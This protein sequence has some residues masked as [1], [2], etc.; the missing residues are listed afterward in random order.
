MCSKEGID[1]CAN[2]NI[3]RDR[4]RKTQAFD[5]CIVGAETKLMRQITFRQKNN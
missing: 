3:Q 4:G 2:V 1:S 5:C